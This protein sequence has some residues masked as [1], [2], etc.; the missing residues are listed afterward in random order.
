METLSQWRERQEA[1]V[2]ALEHSR[3]LWYAAIRSKDG[4]LGQ[5]DVQWDEL[6]E[7]NRELEDTVES[8]EERHQQAE[9][10]LASLAQRLSV[11]DET[12]RRTR[13]N[14]GLIVQDR[15]ME[16]ERLDERQARHRELVIAAETAER[17]RT[18]DLVRRERA[19][20]PREAAVAARWEQCDI[21]SNNLHAQG[22][23]I[24]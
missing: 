5:L 2:L 17:R 16:Q 18:Q 11:A 22:I 24:D 19:L 10:Q 21:R 7:R 12:L 13:A 20:E 14:E 6:K 1:A 23:A 15:L 3:G 8:T 4:K 9:R